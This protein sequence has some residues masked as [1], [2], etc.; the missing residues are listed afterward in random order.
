LHR[1]R[2]LVDN[3]HATTNFQEDDLLSTR[4]GVTREDLDDARWTLAGAELSAETLDDA[5]RENDDEKRSTERGG[6]R[7]NLAK[8]AALTRTFGERA[9]VASGRFGFAWE[10]GRERAGWRR[11]WAHWGHWG[12]RRRSD[13]RGVRASHNRVVG[14]R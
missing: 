4:D 12:G 3:K 1:L 13:R 8:E 10:R 5:P 7:K 9:E 14:A 2:T 11:R 6:C